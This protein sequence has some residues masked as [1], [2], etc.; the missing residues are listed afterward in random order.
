MALLNK[1][2]AF[3]GAGKM[4]EALIRG[5]LSSGAIPAAK[6]IASD[7]Q[8]QRLAALRSKYKIGISDNIGAAKKADIVILSIKPQVMQ[9]VLLEISPFVSS[10]QLV[11]SIA[12]GITTASIKKKIRNAPVIRVMPNN[13]ALVSAG[14]SAI[15]AGALTA[16]VKTARAIFNSVG[17][18][19]LVPERLMDAVTALSGSGPA[20]VYLFAEALI[21]AGLALGLNALQAEKLSIKTVFGAAKTMVCSG[22]KPRELREMVTSPGGT[23]LAGL[24]TLQKAGFKRAVLEALRSAKARSTALGKLLNR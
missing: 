21:N 8:F 6:I 20:F 1:K 14:I 9:D 12:A 15:A 13:P 2:I 19:I 10:K 18:T 3:I 11:I 5:L 17:E 23:T 22:L 7:T 16:N 24:K 4:A